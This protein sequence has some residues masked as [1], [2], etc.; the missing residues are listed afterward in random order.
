[1]TRLDV[2]ERLLPYLEDL[3][4]TGLWGTTV[5]EVCVRLLEKG[6]EAE[7]SAGVIGARSNGQLLPGD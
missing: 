6:L 3:L 5:Q 7:I 2:P 4:R 1:M